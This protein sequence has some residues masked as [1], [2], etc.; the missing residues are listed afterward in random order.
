MCCDGKE[1]I[2]VEP[3]AIPAN[4]AER[5]RNTPVSETSLIPI[6]DAGVLGWRAWY[7]DGSVY[8]SREIAWRDL[9]A[10][11]IQIVMLYE[12]E[13][14]LPGRHYRRQF[15]EADFYVADE[16][17]KLGTVIEDEQFKKIN[18]AALAAESW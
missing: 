13:Q 4:N 7:A 1:I 6:Q 11:G 10:E 3:P 16:I 14:F 5:L 9:P 12:T 2:V 17:S 8:D 18:A 15:A